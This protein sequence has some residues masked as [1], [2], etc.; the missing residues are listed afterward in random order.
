MTYR[1]NIN[2]SQGFFNMD[3]LLF[4]SLINFTSLFT[5]HLPNLL[6][7]ECE[8]YFST[9]TNSLAFP[10]SRM[11]SSPQSTDAIPLLDHPFKVSP[12]L[13]IYC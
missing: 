5:I 1:L 10:F 7:I 2:F 6:F 11:P 12:I 4:Y 13:H 9:S 3:V 8:I